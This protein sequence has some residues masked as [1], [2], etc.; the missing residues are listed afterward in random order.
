MEEQQEQVN[1]SNTS[2]CRFHQPWL[3]GGLV[4]WLVSW[5]V[6]R[7]VGWTRV[8]LFLV[9]ANGSAVGVNWLVCSMFTNKLRRRKRQA[10]KRHVDLRP[11][12]GFAALN[13]V[14]EN[15]CIHLSATMW[16]R[17]L[18]RARVKTTS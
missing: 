10:T 6:G 18:T 15:R 7:L 16:R 4:C 3:G 1:F 13:C 2:S 11:A 5:S 12:R 14:R 9:T 17:L 8:T